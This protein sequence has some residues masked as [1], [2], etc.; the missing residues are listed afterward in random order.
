MHVPKC[1]K[2]QIC[3]HGQCFVRVGRSIHPSD[4]VEK[5][6]KNRSDDAS[7]ASRAKKTRFF[8]LRTRL[9]VDF[10][11]LGP[12]RSVPGRLFGRP[13]PSL[14]TLLELASGARRG[15][16]RDAP[17]RLWDVPERHWASRVGPGTEFRS[18]LR[19]PGML[20][21]RFWIDFRVDF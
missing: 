12:L 19:A 5:S 21:D 10:R 20:R 18:N 7:R 11:R 13:G 3:R 9:G 4:F 2:P 1:A 15:R 16:S 6:S 14:G 17:R 8:R